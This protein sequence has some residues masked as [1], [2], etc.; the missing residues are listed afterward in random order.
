MAR[1]R[2]TAYLNDVVGGLQLG[3]GIGV[4]PFELLH[5]S[6]RIFGLLVGSGVRLTKKHL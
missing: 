3:Q 4:L 5:A 6:L 2:T 1:H